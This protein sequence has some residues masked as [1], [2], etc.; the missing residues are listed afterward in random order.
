MSRS[1][2]FRILGPVSALAVFL[3]LKDQGENPALMAGLVI[4]MAIWWISEAV[5]IP[6][7]SLLPLVLFPLLGIEDLHSTAA[8]YGNEVIYLFLGGFLI[9]LGIERSGAH[10]RIALG[11]VSLI[12]GSPARLMLGI[13]VACAMLSMWINST[14][15]TLVMLPIALSLLD[16]EDAPVLVRDRLTIPLLLSVAYGATIGG[17]ATPVGTPPNLILKGFLQNRSADGAAIGFGE[18]TAFGIPIAVVLIAFAWLVLSRIVFRV[19]KEPLGDADSIA[20]RRKAL[21]PLTGTEFRSL[22]VFG[23]VALAWITGDDLDLSKDLVVKGWRSISFLA[24]VGDASIA[25]AGAIALFVIPAV[26]TSVM[27]STPRLMDWDFAVVR[28]PWGVLLLIGGGFALGSG[29]ESSGLSRLIGLALADLGDLPPVL[30]IGSVVLIV[31]LLSEVGSNTA[32]ASLVIPILAGA[33]D[34]WGMDL[35]ALLIPATLGAS[36]GFMLPVASPMQ[37][38]VF[39]TGRIPMQQMVRAGVWMDLFGVLFFALVFGLL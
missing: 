22:L 36:L 24:G 37:T 9:A 7:T 15:A 4:W 17:M 14:A 16:D 29:V 28:V 21:G 8:N 5:P 11:I 27:D 1:S 32:T 6:I 19:G 38:I 10:R 20:A 3:F 13:M 23:A 34:S 33:A 12:G 35:Q 18:W 2:F 31:C 30:L 26:R 39:G 25:V